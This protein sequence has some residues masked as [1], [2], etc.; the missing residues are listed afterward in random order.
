MAQQPN[1]KNILFDLGGVI[2]DIN[3]QATLKLFYELGFPSKLMQIPNSMTTDIY[4]KY[5]TGK[6]S[7]KEFRNQIRL[8]SGVEISDQA[9]DEAWSAMLVR[10]PK[11]R[12]DLLR[13]LSK[14]YNLYMLSNTSALHVK[15]FEKM[16]LEAAG[17]S[18]YKVFKKIYYSHE[19]GWYKPEPEA[20]EHVI[21]DADIKAE[22]TL[23]LDDNIHNIKASQELGF[24]AIHIHERT[25]LMNLGFDL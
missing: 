16:Y 22:E 15:E 8:A 6:L 1:F 12:I 11:E 2:L 19:I 4:Y 25:N 7:T 13:V 23:F 10:F 21:K 5:E 14:H 20:W 17:E 18:I 3:V 24:Q 9:F